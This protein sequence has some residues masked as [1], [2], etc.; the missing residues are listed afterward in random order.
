M[1]F[2]FGRYRKGQAFVTRFLPKKA[3]ELRQTTQSLTHTALL[4]KEFLLND[5]LNAQASQVSK[6][7][8]VFLIK[9]SI[10]LSSRILSKIAAK[11]S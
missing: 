2:I 3:G 6:T 1:A 7:C 5:N 4:K 8:E 10:S 9:Y 11:R